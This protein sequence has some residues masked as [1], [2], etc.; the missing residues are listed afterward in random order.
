[1]L[2]KIL[3]HKFAALPPNF[4]PARMRAYPWQRA[5]VA[6]QSYGLAAKGAAPKLWS[7]FTNNL[8]VLFL[9]ALRKIDPET[10]GR[11]EEY[12]INSGPLNGARF[13][14]TR[15]ELTNGLELIAGGIIHTEIPFKTNRCLSKAE[16]LDPKT[17]KWTETGEMRTARFDHKATLLPDGKVL[18]AGGSDIKNNGVSSD[19]LYDPATGSWNTI[20]NK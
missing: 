2:S 7:V 6:L 17:G 11:A 3:T 5:L 9:D 15:T 10:A 14:Y 19:E 8:N 16:L 13:G 12:L 4:W 1:V 20:T 18:V